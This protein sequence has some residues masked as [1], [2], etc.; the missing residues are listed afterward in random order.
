MRLLSMNNEVGRVGEAFLA[1]CALKCF[2]SEV[3]SRDVNTQVAAVEKLLLSGAM[4]TAKFL[5]PH[6]VC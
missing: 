6:L 1:F 2:L 5:L 3:E 4:G